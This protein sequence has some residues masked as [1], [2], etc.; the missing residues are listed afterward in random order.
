MKRFIS[1]PILVLVLIAL[2]LTS[3]VT[4]KIVTTPEVSLEGW[5]KSDEGYGFKLHMMEG[6]QK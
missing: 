4:Y 3:A 6:S 5:F 1:S 2:T